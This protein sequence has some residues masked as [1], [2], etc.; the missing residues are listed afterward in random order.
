M[1]VRKTGLTVLMVLLMGALLVSCSDSDKKKVTGPVALPPEVI[2]EVV[3]ESSYKISG[4]IIDETSDPVANA[5]VRLISGEESSLTY[6]DTNGSYVFSDINIGQY[7]VTSEKAGFTFTSTKASVTENGVSIKTMTLK[8]MAQIENRTETETTAATIKTSGVEVKSE[9]QEDVSTGTGTTS[10]TQQV[11]AAI[12]PATEITIDG[13]V[14]EEEIVLSAAPMKADQIPQ[15]GEDELP[16]SAI[17]LEPQGAEFSEPVA[18][19]MPMGIQLPAGT[20][21]PV[22]KLEDGVWVTSGE[23][24]I[25]SEGANMD[26]TEFGQYSLQVKVQTETTED[27]N[28]VTEVAAAVEV[29]EEQTSVELEATD[30]I[31]FSEPLPEGLSASYIQSLI[32]QQTGASFGVAKAVNIANPTKTVQAQQAAKVAGEVYSTWTVQLKTITSDNIFIYGI[33]LDGDGVTDIDLAIPYT[34][35]EEIWEPVITDTVVI[36]WIDVNVTDAGGSAI[37]GATLT[38]MNANIGVLETV[39][40]GTVTSRFKGLQGQKYDVLIAMDGYTFDQAQRSSGVLTDDIVINFIGTKAATYS[41]VS[42]TVS[43]AAGVD[44]TLTGPSGTK[45]QNVTANGGTYAFTVLN[46]ASY[47]VSAAKTNYGFVD[48]EPINNISAATTRDFT[49]FQ[50]SATISGTVTGTGNV[51]V[52]LSDGAGISE[53][54]TVA[55]SGDSF[56]FATPVPIG[57][58]FSLTATKTDYTFSSDVFVLGDL[59]VATVDMMSFPINAHKVVPR[60]AIS[61]RFD[62]PAGTGAL[63]V[64]LSSPDW[65]ASKVRSIE[66]G[67]DVLFEN[68]KAGLDFTL[69]ATAP[70]GTDL[71]Q[72]TYSYTGLTYSPSVVFDAVQ[73]F[74]ISG[75][76][77]DQFGAAISGATVALSGNDNQTQT[78]GAGGTYTFDVLKDGNYVVTP[79]KVLYSLNPKATSIQGISQSKTANFTGTQYVTISGTVTDTS[80]I[81]GAVTVELSGGAQGTLTQTVASGGGSYLFSVKAGSTYRVAARKTGI[82]FA[83]N[84]AGDFVN[85]KTN[86]RHNFRIQHSSGTGGN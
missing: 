86:Q 60:V 2:E 44:V 69:V 18:V 25:G 5:K 47:T 56:T 7:T 35:T 27:P 22:K 43:G 71:T 20:K 6:T 23:A 76:L 67:N 85:I 54:I 75:V 13:V 16:L 3:T 30:T 62:A 78:T 48:A 39:T 84:S 1:N 19:T 29:P 51:A 11:K 45:S 55:N 9:Y 59:N 38:F 49:A 31:E 37:P 26:V 77:T 10:K 4:K 81:S 42:G 68:L 65:T 73:Y 57:D 70:A 66:P 12:P 28:P 63:T 82:T 21:I 46:G 58:T 24:E 83:A 40:T 74:A 53:T 41:T 52:W 36:W 79:S 50:L 34:T 17:V 80:T 14:V 33:D 15:A 61:A 72:D 8:S 32:E 64:T